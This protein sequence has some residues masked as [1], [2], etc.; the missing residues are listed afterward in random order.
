MLNNKNLNNL[1]PSQ[2]SVIFILTEQVY[3]PLDSVKNTIIILNYSS[4]NKNNLYFS[5]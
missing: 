5:L 4:N 2:E 3:D 1:A